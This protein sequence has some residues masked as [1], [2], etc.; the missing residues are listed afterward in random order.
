MKNLFAIALLAVMTISC[1]SPKESQ[2]SVP[3]NDSTVVLAPANDSTAD[4]SADSTAV[5]Q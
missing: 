1:G 3:A 2:E 5:A 4:S